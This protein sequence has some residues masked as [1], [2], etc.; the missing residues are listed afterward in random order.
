MSIPRVHNISQHD[1][2]NKFIIPNKPCI[3]TGIANNWACFR[4]WTSLDAFIQEHEND[5]VP[6]ITI[7]QCR[8]KCDTD[9]KQC[10]EGYLVRSSEEDANV[11]ISELF[12]HR[13]DE[14][15][16][17][18]RRLEGSQKSSLTSSCLSP[19]YL[20][21]FHYF[22]EKEKDKEFD[23]RKIYSLPTFLGEE[24]IFDF[25]NTFSNKN[26]SARELNDDIFLDESE[27]SDDF[28][29]VY[30]GEKGTRTDLHFDVLC[31]FSWSANICGRK[32]W[33]LFDSKVCDEI[34]SN[35]KYNREFPPLE[36]YL[37]EHAHDSRNK[38]H[39][40][41]IQEP[42][43]IVF[44]PS[45]WPHFV[46]NLDDAVS[47][48][49]NWFNACNLR[50][51]WLH[52]LNGI[53]N[54]CADVVGFDDFGEE[55][56]SSTNSNRCTQGCSVEDVFK[57]KLLLDRLKCLLP[58]ALE[59]C[60]LETLLDA[61]TGSGN[62]DFCRFEMIIETGKKAIDEL[63]LQSRT[64]NSV[65]VDPEFVNFSEQEIIKYT[66]KLDDLYECL[67]QLEDF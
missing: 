50:F 57:E 4:T 13:K 64:N 30:A 36:K 53:V 52:I 35:P 58:K 48:N 37:K 41:F 20:K 21:D 65:T 63:K 15:L 12:A 47:I 9:I 45:R 56:D 31:S 54:V 44:V 61:L 51:L 6:E 23:P 8:N 42:G 1:F 49:R 27:V 16:C 40:E 43:E 19:L 33:V 39:A 29:F 66:G 3:L 59:K 18:R 2:V 24:R 22:Q 10:G 46:E 62:V 67:P 55:P 7:K 32:R 11:T 25:F 60:D 28:R 5:I 26:P 38:V 14:T 17:K 34:V